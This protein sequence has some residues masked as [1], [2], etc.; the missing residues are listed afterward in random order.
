[1]PGRMSAV[2]VPSILA[3]LT[4]PLVRDHDRSTISDKATVAHIK[5]GKQTGTYRHLCTPFLLL[6][7]KKAEEGQIVPR[8]FDT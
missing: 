3:R 8:A 7:R 2:L 6:R 4:T 1:M 5:E